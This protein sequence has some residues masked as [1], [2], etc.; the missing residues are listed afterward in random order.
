MENIAIIGG[1]TAGLTCAYRLRGK[2]NVTLFEKADRLGGHVR[3][4][5]SPQGTTINPYVC[6]F[7][8][9]LYPEFFKLMNELGFDGF[10]GFSMYMVVHDDG[11]ILHADVPTDLKMLRQNLKTYLDPRNPPS[12]RHWARYYGFLIRFYIDWKRGR[13]PDDM[14][15]EELVQAYPGK[16]DLVEI[17]VLPFSKVKTLL[18]PTVGEM[19]RL[20]FGMTDIRDILGGDYFL[21]ITRP[22]DDYIGLLVDRL[23]AEIHTSTPVERV[24]RMPEGFRVK[25]A[26]QPA[27]R[28]DRV[29]VATHPCHAPQFLDLYTLELKA[30]YENL[31]VMHDP[32]VVVI[33][34][35]PTIMCGIPRRL[36]GPASMN[37]RVE[38][39]QNMVSLYQ[40][41][42][43][44]C[45]EELFVTYMDPYHLD[46]TPYTQ[47]RP[48][49]TSWRD[50]DWQ[51]MPPALRLDPKKIYEVK[52]FNHP[53]FGHPG[54][55]EA[56]RRFADFTAND[57]P[58]YMCGV[59]MDGENR[60]GQEGAV[61]SGTRAAEAILAHMRG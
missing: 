4:F 5:T 18:T 19:A 55:P 46:F 22:I 40:P 32:T 50:L 44:G 8:R 9:G 12:V 59:G 52:Y 58:L 26:G 49:D 13:F 51:S 24:Q 41:E 20:L 25:P 11:H 60:Y 29:V 17:S 23:G 36:W 42:M 37:F 35:D 21:T 10:H 43:I 45:D 54:Q 15:V 48:D 28:F 16:A 1:G 39:R 34:S 47:D 33:H 3:S 6:D 53:I 7:T 38:T 57:E 27:R 2:A 31:E 61:V 14:P 56:F 30:M